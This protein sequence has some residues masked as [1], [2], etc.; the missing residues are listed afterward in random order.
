MDSSDSVFDRPITRRSWLKGAGAGAL[1][2]GAGAVPSV[3]GSSRAPTISTTGTAPSAKPKRGGKLTVGLIGGSA[4]DTLDAQNLNTNLDFARA[5][6]LYDQLIV[7]NADD[8]DENSLAT[9]F[10]SNA[11]ATVWTARLR[12]GVEWHNGKELTADDVL[13]TFKRLFKT[14]SF[15]AQQLALIDA[16]ECEEAGSLHRPH[17]LQAAICR[18]EPVHVSGL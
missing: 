14:Q 8:L 6:Q 17:P 3:R 11:D 9:E 13:Y 5:P 12:H 1:A 7:L 15:V 4:T 18:L 2:L 10:T 16:A